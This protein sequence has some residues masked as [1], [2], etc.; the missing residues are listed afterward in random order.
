M[1]YDAWPNLS[2]LCPCCGGVACAIYRGYYTRFLFCPE[3]EFVGRLVIRTGY[4]RKTGRR[5]ALMPDFLFSR[6]RISRLSQQAL[7]FSFILGA[8]VKPLTSSSRT[9]VT[10]STC[11]ARRRIRTC[12][13]Q[14]FRTLPPMSG[15][16]SHPKS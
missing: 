7:P 14:S 3:M 10:S 1:Q 6:L 12:S 11:R 8:S 15:K 16:M 2:A 9:W 5:F 13:I 4:C